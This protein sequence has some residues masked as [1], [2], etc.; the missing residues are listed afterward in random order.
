MPDSFKKNARLL[1]VVRYAWL[2]AGLLLWLA[3]PLAAQKT[4]REPLT[5]AQQEQIAEAGID[6]AERIALYT[7]FVN[8]RADTIKNLGG[9]HEQ[10]RA[11][12]LDDELQD[13]AALIDELDSN[14][15]EYGERKADLRR[16]LKP[17]NESIARWQ[18]VLHD[19]PNDPVY[20]VA[21]NDAADAINDLADDAKKL[22][23]DQE[24]YFSEHKDAKGQQ[25]EEPK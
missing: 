12:R 2:M 16:S 21:R 23:A 8:E 7:K 9:R 4:Q 22:T 3:L 5:E 17:L 1:S 10:G 6:P 11:R 18:A 19:L 15:D 25:R 14:L 20:E 24:K 13:F